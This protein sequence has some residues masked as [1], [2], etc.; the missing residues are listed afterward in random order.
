MS[1][2]IPNLNALCIPSMLPPSSKEHLK[3][4]KRTE[5]VSKKKQLKTEGST[6][7]K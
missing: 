5:P 3:T 7:V 2:R 6:A 4:Y 1:N